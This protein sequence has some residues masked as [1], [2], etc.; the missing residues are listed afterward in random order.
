MHALKTAA[1]AVSAC[2]LLVA[3]S[4]PASAATDSAQ[5]P[6]AV[7][8]KPEDPNDARMR[9]LRA[10]QVL[11][12]ARRGEY[13]RL[14]YGRMRQI[15]LST[16]SI[17]KTLE[18]EERIDRLSPDKLKAFNQSQSS[19][20]EVLAS[21]DPDRLVCLKEQKTGSRILKEVCMTIA[22]RERLAKEAR[23]S[24]D[25]MINKTLCAPGMSDKCAP[26]N[27]NVGGGQ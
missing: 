17:L 8:G 27:I 15:E 1:F 16:T 3:A 7:T 4:P 25:A 2:V 10:R 18:G 19:L 26:M 24:A 23:E 9:S 13:G 11:E 5:A 6:A 14:N 12:M 20:D 22:G 21:L